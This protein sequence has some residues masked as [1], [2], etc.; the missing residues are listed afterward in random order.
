MLVTSAALGFITDTTTS[1]SRTASF[2]DSAG[3]GAL[4]FAGIRSSNELGAALLE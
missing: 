2:S 1:L 3:L 4:V